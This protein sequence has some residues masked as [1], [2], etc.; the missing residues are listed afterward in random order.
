[1]HVEEARTDCVDGLDD[2]G[3]GADAVAHVDAAAH[4]RV[5]VLDG[6]EHVERR[7]PDLVFRPVVVDGDAD[8]VLLDELFDARQSCGRGVAGDDD[9]DAGAL[10]VLELGADVVVFI[11]GKV[12]GSGGVEL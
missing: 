9:A 12:D 7:G 3:A 4:A 10:A 2:I 6:L 11:L 1:M 8:V 5:H